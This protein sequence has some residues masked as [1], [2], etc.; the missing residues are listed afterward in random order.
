IASDS[1]VNYTVHYKI[2]G[3]GVDKDPV[4]LFTL[5]SKTGM[6]S[7]TR[8]VDREQYPQFNFIAQV[9]DVNGRETDQYLPITVN[10]QDMNDNAPEFRGVRLFTVEERCRA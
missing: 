5:N 1:S 8:A 4:G 7:V 9:F 6:L 2:S 10:V 3:Q